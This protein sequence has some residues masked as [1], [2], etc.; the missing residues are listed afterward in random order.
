M[1]RLLPALLALAAVSA[2]ALAQNENLSFSQRMSIYRACKPDIDAKC[3]N[4][5]P[6]RRGFRPAC[7][8]TNRSS[9]TAASRR[10]AKPARDK[11]RRPLIGSAGLRQR[12]LT[13][14]RRPPQ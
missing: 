13:P 10:S 1:T 6:I 2:P 9:R 3:P 8:P 14:P 4:A 7:A 12:S 5:G 11:A